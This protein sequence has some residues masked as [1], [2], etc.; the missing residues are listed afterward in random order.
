MNKDM[1]DNTKTNSLEAK[2]K[3]EL[4]SLIITFFVSAIISLAI[5]FGIRA[6]G[7]YSINLSGESMAPTFHDGT[8]L[9][10]KNHK[11]ETGDIVVFDA[12]KS[13]DE[14]GS[15]KFIKRIVAIPGDTLIITRDGILV[16]NKRVKTFDEKYVKRM[17]GDVELNKEIKIPKDKYFVMGDNY[18]NSN[19]SLYE[20]LRMNDNFL[21]NGDQIF[22]SGEKLF[23]FNYKFN[24]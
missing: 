24:K 18:Q 7:L 16:N 11:P 6:A 8:L 17:I 19:D 2:P 5:I 9:V 23:S 12:D 15:K 13:W 4:V 3:S 21:V 20:F 14:T 10:I 1:K 22:T